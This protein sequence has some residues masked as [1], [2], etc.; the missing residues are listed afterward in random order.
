MESNKSDTL[1]EESRFVLFWKHPVKWF[2]TRKSSKEERK[3]EAAKNAQ[4][5]Q[6]LGPKDQD[7]EL[8]DAEWNMNIR[9]DT[10]KNSLVYSGL[11][12]MGA[13]T[14][15]AGLYGKTPPWV[16]KCFAASLLLMLFGGIPALTELFRRQP[17]AKQLAR[18]RRNAEAAAA[19]PGEAAR[20]L[21]DKLRTGMYTQILQR[22][23]HVQ[24][25]SFR[26]RWFSTLAAVA[27]T[28]GLSWLFF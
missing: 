12:F 21:R 10:A 1:D 4:Y 3:K 28:A 9:Y 15:L 11:V 23:F 2:K 14:M 18:L 27:F 8:Y 24:R 25:N 19:E 7:A 17:T 16:M 22:T 6:S 26:L 13:C 5:F 20:T